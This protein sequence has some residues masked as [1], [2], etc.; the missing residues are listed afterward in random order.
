MKYD[1]P[2]VAVLGLAL[3]AVHHQSKES[4]LGIDQF[5][6]VTTPTAYEADE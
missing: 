3:N 2:E 6:E 4:M 1:K 5:R